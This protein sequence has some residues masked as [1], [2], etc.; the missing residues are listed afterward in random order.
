MESVRVNC[1]DN[2]RD[3]GALETTCIKYAKYKIIKIS[4]GCQYVGYYHYSEI[5]SWAA[6]KFVWG[7]T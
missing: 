6:K 5:L 3:K 2:R 1:N 7:R 4:T